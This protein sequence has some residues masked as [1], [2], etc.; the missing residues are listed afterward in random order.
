M[1]D[2]KIPATLW[3]PFFPGRKAGIVAFN[4]RDLIIVSRA[5][6]VPWEGQV[7]A[8]PP[9]AGCPSVWGRLVDIKPTKTV[10]IY[11]CSIGVGADGK[12]QA[13]LASSSEEAQKAV[14]HRECAFFASKDAKEKEAAS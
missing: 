10:G 7:K 3:R 6:S 12:G 13:V 11:T 1:S 4:G 2:Q 9:K 8:N 5:T 14:A